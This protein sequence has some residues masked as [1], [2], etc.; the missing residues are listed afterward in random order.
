VVEGGGAE[1]IGEGTHEN[2]AKPEPK[3]DGKVGKQGKN[4]AKNEA[5]TDSRTQGTTDKSRKPQASA[6]EAGMPVAKA[7]AKPGR[8]TDAQADAQ[9]DGQVES[10]EK[11][12]KVVGQHAAVAKRPDLARAAAPIVAA[13]RAEFG[14]ALLRHAPPP[15]QRWVVLGLAVAAALILVYLIAS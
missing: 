13:G 14:A 1:A 4:E 11:V 5:K 12:E 8:K 2:R 7:D 6:A 9:A 10:T 3:S 15:H